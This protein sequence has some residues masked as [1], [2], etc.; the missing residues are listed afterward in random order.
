MAMARHR[1][2]VNFLWWDHIKTT[3]ATDVA[4][5]DKKRFW[6]GKQQEQ[7]TLESSNPDNKNKP[8][9][10]REKLQQ[11]PVMEYGQEVP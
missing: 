8:P 11:R 3:L 4:N 2:V 1:E 10:S 7:I 9:L 5:R 6:F